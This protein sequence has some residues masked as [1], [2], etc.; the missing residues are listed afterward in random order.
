MDI[1]KSPSGIIPF[2]KNSV[3]SEMQDDVSCSKLEMS[4][5]DN[6]INPFDT[7]LGLRVP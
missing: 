6:K 3:S 7:I 5:N 2:L 4:S 1:A